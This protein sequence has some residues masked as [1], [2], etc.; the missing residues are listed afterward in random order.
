MDKKLVFNR[1][2]PTTIQDDY[3]DRVLQTPDR[4]MRPLVVFVLD[5]PRESLVDVEGSELAEAEALG[6]V[7]EQHHLV[8]MGSGGMDGDE[9][10]DLVLFQVVFPAAA[11]DV[12]EDFLLVGTGI[13][14]EGV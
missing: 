2:D 11:R 8:N 12:D 3:T 7:D 6:D 14:S 1:E 13:G 4:L 5:L 10:G 9:V